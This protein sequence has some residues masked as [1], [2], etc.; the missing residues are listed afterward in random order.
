MKPL[1]IKIEL[2]S[3]VICSS[4]ICL[5]ALLGFS[6][7][8]ETN[9]IDIAHNELP[10]KR[11]DGIW[12][13]SQIRIQGPVKMEEVT[14]FASL[15]EKDQDIRSFSPNNKKGDEYLFID[16]AR[17]EHKASSDKYSSY[18]SRENIIHFFAFGDEDKVR[19]LLRSNV[20]AIGK[21]HNH[22]YGSIVKIEVESI[23]E[24]YSIYH[25]DYGVMRSIPCNS[26]LS[27][28]FNLDS[29]KDIDT[30]L[31]SFSPPYYEGE[32]SSCYVPSSI[33]IDIKAEEVTHD[34]F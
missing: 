19:E 17:G 27:K 30:E 14:F 22:G 21:K 9:D 8:Q 6:L 26:S 10:L 28:E 1:H 15:K 13:A 12:H 20:F 16:T 23:S 29:I 7:F 32:R 11:T 18:Q 33:E 2:K 5:D 3:P 4:P 31:T 24:D 25:P 34:V